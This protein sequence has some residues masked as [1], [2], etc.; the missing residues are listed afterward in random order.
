LEMSSARAILVVAPGCPAALI[1]EILD[2]A[3]LPDQTL[4]TVLLPPGDPSEYVSLRDRDIPGDLPKFVPSPALSFLSMRNLLWLRNHLQDC[5]KIN[6]LLPKSPYKDPTLAIT[7]PLMLLLTGRFINLLRPA[8][9]QDLREQLGEGQEPGDQKGAPRWIKKKLDKAL[10]LKEF[11][12]LIWSS[13]PDWLRRLFTW[14]ERE[15]CYYLKAYPTDPANLK[16]LDS[17]PE[18]IKR[19]V[20]YSLGTSKLVL[21]SLPGGGALLKGKRVLEIGPGVN[22]GTILTLACYGAEV[23]A[24][25]RFATPWNPDYHPKFY[26]LLR[27]RLAKSKADLDLTPLEMIVSQGQYPRDCF[28]VYRC[29]LEEL[30]VV[31][32]HSVDLVFSN[33]VFEHLYDLDS[34]F[35][36]LARITKPGG[37][38]LHQVDF[39]D[40]RDPSRP[41]EHLLFDDREFSRL[42]QE[43][44]S[45]CG[46]RFRVEEMQHLLEKAGFEV[47][48]FQPDMYAEEEYLKEFLVRLRQAKESRYRYYRAEDLRSVSGLFIMLRKPL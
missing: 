31:P 12:N 6:L 40:H 5:E 41:L 30:R 10:L 46:N 14:T 42:F 28:S 1:Q 13:Y 18:G 25:E 15:L 2:T 23:M 45:E 39:R 48:K 47:R 33:A 3:I 34:A 36:H 20:E 44:H 4:Q 17:S 24:V 43:K 11:G 21:R 22:F 19:D 16:P 32:D 8:T 38:G 9:P 35:G 26:A 37:L 27:D 29:S 7:T